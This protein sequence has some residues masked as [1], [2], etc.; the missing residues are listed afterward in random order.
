MSETY[1]DS[2]KYLVL[3]ASQGSQAAFVALFYRYKSKLYGYTLRLTGSEML[4]EDIVQDVFMKLWADHISLASID[5]FDSYLFRMSKNH[6]LNHFKRVAHETAIV[7]EMFRNGEPGNNNVH[8]M[9]AA[10]EV[11]QVLRSVVDTLPPQQRAVYRLSREEE[12]SHEEIA[13]LLKI[14][15]NTVKNH[16]VQAMA[17]IRTQLRRHADSLLVA[18]MLLSLKK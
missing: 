4:A 10:R 18:A 15:P 7:S 3:S 8:E 12:K 16:I 6:V 14:S 9:L 17:T 13:D 1:S 5:N 11:E 2:D